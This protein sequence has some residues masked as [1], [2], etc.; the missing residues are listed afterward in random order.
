[1]CA[2]Q[3]WSPWTLCSN[4]SICHIL[5]VTKCKKLKNVTIKKYL[6]NG[7]LHAIS[8]LN[9]LLVLYFIVPLTTILIWTWACNYKN[10]FRIQVIPSMF[11]VTVLCLSLK[12]SSIHYNFLKSIQ[13]LMFIHHVLIPN[14]TFLY[15]LKIQDFRWMLLGHYPNTFSYTKALLV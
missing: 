6:S 2:D 10:R 12:S 11:C 3:I 5:N 1:M 8:N 4:R 15:S 9:K 14:I 7:R 13:R